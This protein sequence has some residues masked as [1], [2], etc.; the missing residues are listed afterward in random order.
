[1]GNKVKMFRPLTNRFVQ[2]RGVYQDE[3]KALRAV[4]DD[5]EEKRTSRIEFRGNESFLSY[6]G[7]SGLSVS[8]FD[9]IPSE[10]IQV[11]EQEADQLE[12]Y[13][14]WFPFCK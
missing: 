12:I 13:C 1:L 7:H 11:T 9:P 10:P 4:S 6:L 14:Y 3:H 8:E 2:L 5:S